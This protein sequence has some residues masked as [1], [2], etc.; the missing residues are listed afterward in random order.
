MPS[1]FPTT[2]DSFPTNKADGTAMVV[3]HAATHNLLADAINKIELYARVYA[4]K[5]VASANFPFPE[6]ADYQC[7][8]TAD[9][10]QIQAAIDA[11]PANDEIGRAHV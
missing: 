5:T 6:L 4:T 11:L 1:T 3:D 10:V 2:L 8:G 7:D 9:Q